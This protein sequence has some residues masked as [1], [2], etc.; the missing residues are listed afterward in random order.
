MQAGG[1]G[2]FSSDASLTSFICKV[3]AVGKQSHRLQLRTGFWPGL[4]GYK[5]RERKTGRGWGLLLS[6]FMFTGEA[7]GCKEAPR[8]QL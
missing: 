3:C 5:G 7:A 2:W 1:S 6:C 4:S 8:N